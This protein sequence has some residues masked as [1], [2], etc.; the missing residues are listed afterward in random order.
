MYYTEIEQCWNSKSCTTPTSLLY[1]LNPSQSTD[2]HHI[3][4]R[5]FINQEKRDAISRTELRY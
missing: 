3:I 2:S 1:H 4:D 5:I